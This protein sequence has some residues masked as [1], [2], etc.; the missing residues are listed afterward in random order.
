ME[1]LGADSLSLSPC[2]VIS[3]WF[4]PMC[5]RACIFTDPSSGRTRSPSEIWWNRGGMRSLCCLQD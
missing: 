1:M 2:S 3:E 5:S 4:S